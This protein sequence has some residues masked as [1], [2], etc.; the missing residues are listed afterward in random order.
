MVSRLK[1]RDTGAVGKRIS[2]PEN[3]RPSPNSLRPKFSF[4][5]LVKG[6]CIACCERD[7]KVALLDRLH[8]MSQ[9]TWQ[10]LVEAPRHGQGY[11]KIAKTSMKVAIPSCLTQDSN[12]LSFRFSGKKPMVGFRRDEVFFVVWLDR[13]FTVYKHS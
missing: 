11:E 10:K 5:H 2:A 4:E 6:Y 13:D 3:A 9:Q 7:E 1:G 12:I 8:E